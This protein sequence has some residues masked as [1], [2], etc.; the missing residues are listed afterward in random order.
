MPA[1]AKQAE[2]RHI[3]YFINIFIPTLIGFAVIA[4]IIYY[5]RN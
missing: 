1:A 2:I 3:K 5:T 4:L